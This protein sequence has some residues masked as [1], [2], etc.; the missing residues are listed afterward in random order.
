MGTTS[1]SYENENGIFPCNFLH[2]ITI[3]ENT[4]SVLP[5]FKFFG[6]EKQINKSRLIK[7]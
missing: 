4:Q 7:T 5:I 3:R 1:E 6:A 2:F